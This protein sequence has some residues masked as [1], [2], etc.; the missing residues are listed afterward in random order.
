MPEADEIEVVTPDRLCPSDNERL[1]VLIPSPERSIESV[2]TAENF[3][4]QTFQAFSPHESFANTLVIRG[5]RQLNLKH[6]DIT[7]PHNSLTWLQGSAAVG[8]RLWFLIPF[9]LKGSGAIWTVFRLGAAIPGS[10]GKTQVDQITGLHPDG[11]NRA[12]NTQP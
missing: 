7:I 5:A 11:G 6:L 3:E 2:P 4:A 10:D 12:E 8:N 9:T 1:A